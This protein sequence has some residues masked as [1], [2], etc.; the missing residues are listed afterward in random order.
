[1]RHSPLV[2]VLLVGLGVGVVAAFVESIVASYRTRWTYRFREVIR[3]E[4]DRTTRRRPEVDP[5]WQVGAGRE[6]QP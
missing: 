1:M 3:Q 4:P 5:E 2:T 6:R